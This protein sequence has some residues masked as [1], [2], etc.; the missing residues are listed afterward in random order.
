MTRGRQRQGAILRQDANGKARRAKGL[1][2]GRRAAAIAD[3]PRLKDAFVIAWR[4]EDDVAFR[5]AHH[6]FYPSPL[7]RLWAI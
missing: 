5:I 6:A 7:R 2:P 3:D 1:M 4:V